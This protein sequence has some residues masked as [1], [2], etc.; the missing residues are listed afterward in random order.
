MLAVVTG[1][2]TGGHIIPAKAIMDKFKDKGWQVL[3][4]GSKEG[5][6][7]RIIGNDYNAMFISVK[8]IKGK[9][10]SDTMKALWL[11]ILAFFRMLL[12]FIKKKPD[13]I[14]GTGGFVCMPSIFAGKILGKPVYL[15]E[16]NAVPGAAIKL[17]SKIANKVFLGF[18]E[19]ERMFPKNKAVF[20][21]NPIRKEFCNDQKGY[22]IFKDGE[23]M[24]VLV[25]GGSKGARFINS[26]IINTLPLLNKDEFH[27]FHQ[28][29]TKEKEKVL[30]AY[31]NER[32]SSYVFDFCPQIH[33]Y[34][35][36]AHFIIARA[37]A[38]TVSEVLSAKRPALFIPF[39]YAIYDHQAAN[40]KVAVNMGAALMCRENEITPEKLS[41]LLNSLKQAPE[42]LIAMSRAAKYCDDDPA[43]KIVNLIIKESFCV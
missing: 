8:G 42:S 15:Q 14:I 24:N 43:D 41:Q 35:F 6:E 12:F 3:Y 22:T 11:L 18:K 4:V 21:G 40:A 38:M 16:Q 13:V 33:E 7:K 1:G 30:N 10:L 37:G 27:F 19:A 36:K 34:Y 25:L 23:R 28:T 31:I 2:G 29:G 32:V 26:L 9:N 20:T 5:M 39:P 17:G